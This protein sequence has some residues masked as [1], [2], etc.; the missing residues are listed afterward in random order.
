MQVFVS[1]WESPQSAGLALF[2]LHRWG[3]HSL[4]LDL[5]VLRNL[6]CSTGLVQGAC[7]QH[8]CWQTLWAQQAGAVHVGRGQCHCGCALLES[9]EAGLSKPRQTCTACSWA[10]GSAFPYWGWLGASFS[11]SR[12]NHKAVFKSPEDV[13]TSVLAAAGTE[14][15]E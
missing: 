15:D 3:Q 2:E 6:S 5:V 12:G 14:Q 8:S 7:S 13:C 9:G 10:W 1:I 4:K 11:S